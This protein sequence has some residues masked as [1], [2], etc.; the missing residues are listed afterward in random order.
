MVGGWLLAKSTGIAFI[1]GLTDA[2]SVQAA[3]ALAAG[4]ATVAVLIAIAV[5]ASPSIQPRRLNV[6]WGI[7]AMVIAALTV[8]AMAS[9]GGHSHSGGHGDSAAH[10]HTGTEVASGVEAHHHESQEDANATSPAPAHDDHE[11]SA[12]VGDHRQSAASGV[13]HDHGP[14]IAI[15]AT[16]LEGAA[17]LVSDTTEGVE[18][19]NDLEAAKADGYYQVAPPRNRLVHYMNSAYN[20][21]G[22]ILDPERPESLIYLNLS[23]GSWMLVGAMY[24]MPAPD[25][26]GP[27]VGGPLTAW[28]AHNNLCQA[29][30]RVV[31]VAVD[32]VCARGSLSNT[33]EMLHVWL[34]D[35]PDGVFSD[36][37]EP[38]GLLQPVQN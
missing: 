8:P 6:Q 29:E 2:E 19:F 38:T 3:D 23:D 37:M 31:G 22:R 26:P 36:D 25:Q 30:G 33:P 4:L 1:D 13:V 10:A 7:V 35:N 18:R 12:E 17:R 11:M 24:R 21:D 14:A 32:G 27:R 9:T 34:V 28:H 5:A 15:T 20:R 16:E